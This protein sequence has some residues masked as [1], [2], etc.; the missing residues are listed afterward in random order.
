VSGHYEALGVDR[1]ASLGTIRGAFRKR[2]REAHPDAGGTDEA[3]KRVNLAWS[4]LRDP[5][6]RA[7]Y[8]ATLPKPVE[9]VG[10]AVRVKLSQSMPWGKHEGEL[11][12]DVPSDYLRWV[13]R[14]ASYADDELKRD[15]R[16]ELSKR[17]QRPGSVEYVQR[18]GVVHLS[19][20]G[21]LPMCGSFWKWKP[22]DRRYAFWTGGKECKRGCFK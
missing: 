20:D 11:I 15:I 9:R 21:D 3:M 14:R 18:N 16:A 17:R 6:L 7:E 13:L 2:A 12:A 8:D 10:R 4:V 22:H 19:I 1:S 5:D